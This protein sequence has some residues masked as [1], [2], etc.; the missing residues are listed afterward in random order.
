MR[1]LNIAVSGTHGSGKTTLLH[2]VVATLKKENVNVVL[3]PEAAR[4]SPFLIAKHRSR[5]SQLHILLSH[6]EMEVRHDLLEA[7]VCLSD[8]TPLD[9]LAYSRLFGVFN[10]EDSDAVG[11]FCRWY[12]QRYT[13]VFRTSSVFDLAI[14]R[15]GLRPLNSGLQNDASRVIDELLRE[16]YPDYKKLPQDYEAARDSVVAYIKT[17]LAQQPAALGKSGG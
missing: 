9:I 8:R 2:E 5:E 6:C 11:V 12:M 7:D 16:Y 10:N 4:L 15:D 17:T 3:V 13:A 1:T 14:T